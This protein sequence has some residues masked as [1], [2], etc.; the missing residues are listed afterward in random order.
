M[1]EKKTNNN[2]LPRLA[3]F[4]A[5][6]FAFSW[7]LWVPSAVSGENVN[8]FPWII[9]Y[10]L[11]GFGPSLAGIL[12]TYLEKSP[13][14]QRQFWKRAIDFK[15]IS[16]GWYAFIILIFPF[17]FGLGFLANFLLNGSAPGLETFK[18]LLSN[19]ANLIIVFIAG[20]FTGP[21]AEELGWRG[22]ALDKLQK[23]ISPLASSILL[24]F[25]W[26]AWHIPLFFM[27]GTSQYR[28]G[29]F[30]LESFTFFLGAFSL[31]VMFT[32]VYNQNNRSILAAILLHFA[33][34]FTINLFFPLTQNLLILHQVLLALT[35]LSVVLIYEK[36]KQK[37]KI[38]EIF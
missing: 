23:R 20:L 31:S 15:R 32:W 4:F 13:E 2:H 10:T 27:K 24:G 34:N 3:A 18:Q 22:Y 17:L 14:G 1:D 36:R 33:Y 26:W 37:R 29:F 7:A 21:I 28:M 38:E 16:A 9:A 5:L 19:P 6:A 25:I 35:A 30:S 11:S 12:M 8:T